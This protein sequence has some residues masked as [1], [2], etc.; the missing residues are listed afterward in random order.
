[1]VGI[2]GLWCPSCAWLVEER[3]KRVKGVHAAQ[4]SYVQRKAHI[5]FDPITTEPKKLGRK[6]NLLGYRA[7]LEDE[8]EDEEDSFFTRMLIGG[9]I[10]MH[11]MIIS[12]IIYVREW[13]GLSSVQNEFLEYFFYLMQFVLS[14]PLTFVLGWP[15]IRA[16]LAS[17]VRGLPNIQTLVSL[18]AISA[19]VISSRNLFL[20]TGHI[21]FDTAAML[22]FL[23]TVGRWLEIKAHKAS[24]TVVEEILEGLPTMANSISVNGEEPVAVESLRP[25]SRILIRPGEQFPADGV[26]AEGQGLVDESLLTGEPKSVLRIGGE[27]VFA[28]TI[29][30]DGVFEVIVSRIGV[31]TRAGQVGK[32]LHQA[33]WQRAPVEQLADKLAARIVWG[34]IAISLGTYF[35]W[36]AQ[37]GYEAALLNALSVLLIACP[38]ALGVATPLTLWQALTHAAKNGVV[39]RSTAVIEKLSRIESIYFDKTGTLTQLPLQLQ[40]IASIEQ[41]EN[42]FLSRVVSLEYVS[43]HPFAQTIV[44]EGIQRGVETYPVTEFKVIPG[45]GVSGKVKNT[46]TWIG[47]ANLMEK[48]SLQFPAELTDKI[49]KWQAENLSIIYAGWEGKVR[50]IFGVGESIH[51]DSQAV[52]NTLK[53]AGMQMAIL[54]GD[55]ALR[56][57]Y[58]EDIFG[59]QTH[60][61]LLPE[62]KLSIIKAADASVMMVGDGINDGP[63]LAAAEVGLTFN[64]GTDIAQTAS[65]VILLNDD[66]Y[67][68]PW[69]LSLAHE[70]R[71][72]VRQ[73]L[74]WA[75]AYN[76]VGVGVA[77]SGVLQPVLAAVA[78]LL[79]STFVTRNALR[80]KKFPPPTRD[81]DYKKPPNKQISLSTTVKGS[82]PT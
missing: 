29:N 9:L 64:K 49:E 71:M 6:I 8:P 15:I 2:R 34:A 39:L 72:R 21:Y 54:T 75:L 19:F 66:L 17:L 18:G 24:Q 65:E 22:L 80:L 55:T 51:P 12:L 36:N 26:V 74:M 78:M 25:G 56:G 60:A 1:V 63:S 4:V 28:G 13:L 20:V 59:I 40:K 67:A 47:N 38:C 45:W 43:E 53:E 7:M 41:D 33:L 62:E 44:E 46:P 5:T 23:V 81:F 3:L 14:M 76:L 73:N 42:S 37:S 50:G 30:L 31:D 68:I 77:V 27:P 10:A 11:I 82:L 79:S 32:L 70:A 35:Y 69:L 61:G 52:I 57:A 58:W 48:E 16:G